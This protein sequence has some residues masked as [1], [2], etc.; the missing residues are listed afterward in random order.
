MTRIEGAAIAGVIFAIRW[1]NAYRQHGKGPA[2]SY[3]PWPLRRVAIWLCVFLVPLVVWNVWRLSYYGWLLP[4]TYYAKMGGPSHLL[5]GVVYIGAFG[6][7]ITGGRV[8]LVAVGAVIILGIYLAWR[9]G[10]MR[11]GLVLLLGVIGVHAALVIYSGGDWM[12]YY[13]FIVPVLP[14][15]FLLV[16]VAISGLFSAPPRFSGIARFVGVIVLGLLLFQSGRAVLSDLPSA[17]KLADTT[18]SWAEI[19]RQLRDRYPENTRIAQVSAGA[20]MYESRFRLIDLVGLQD[21]TVA[22]L[23]GDPTLA[24]KFAPVE[25]VASQN[26]DLVILFTY[27][28]PHEGCCTSFIPGMSQLYNSQY[29]QN[30]YKMVDDYPFQEIGGLPAW[31]VLYERVAASS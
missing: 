7:S 1:L 15:V 27:K 17:L 13:R 21:V 2:A 26:P 29:F 12:P 10:V 30:H 5:D 19:G 23:P 18:Y 31:L 9:S 22:H 3:Q 20:I 25:Y 16:A 6:T 28:D 8:G 24:G 14:A 4:N 11:F